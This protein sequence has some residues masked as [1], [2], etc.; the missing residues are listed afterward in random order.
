MPRLKLTEEEARL[1]TRYREQCHA[2][3]EGVAACIALLSE[4]VLAE[5]AQGDEPA[6]EIL[7]SLA[8]LKKEHG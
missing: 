8:K 2:F 4:G 3:N 5:Y 7:N 1:V 6:R